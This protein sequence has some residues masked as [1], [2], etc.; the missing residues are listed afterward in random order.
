MHTQRAATANDRSHPPTM[1]IDL[2]KLWEMQVFRGKHNLQ[3]D[4]LW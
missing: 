3:R 2:L 1:T 4:E